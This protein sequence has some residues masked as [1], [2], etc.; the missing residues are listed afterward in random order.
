MPGALVADEIG[1]GK[2]FTLDAAAMICQLV[3]EIGLM[4]S[5]HSTLWGNTLEEW[6]MLAQNDIPCIVCEDREWL[7]LQRLNSVPSHMLEIQTTPPHRHPELVSD[8]EPILLLTIPGVAETFKTFMTHGTKSA[9][10]NWFHA[11]TEAPVHKDMDTGIDEP[12]NQCSID[13]V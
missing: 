10:V 5:P 13:L 12:D 9:L 1:L 6:V 3:T 8:V 2:P 7:L 4:D 11:E